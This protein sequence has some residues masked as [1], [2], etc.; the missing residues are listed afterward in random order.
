[1]MTLDR[2]GVKC[3][4]PVFQSNEESVY[5]YRQSEWDKCIMG[6]VVSTGKPLNIRDAREVK[7]YGCFMSSL[8]WILHTFSQSI[9]VWSRIP[10]VTVTLRLLRHFRTDGHTMNNF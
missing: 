3:L 7:K 1:M 4:G 6:Y 2:T 10:P 9:Q 5:D 8:I